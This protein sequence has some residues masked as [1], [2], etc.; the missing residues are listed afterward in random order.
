MIP[1]LLI[2][3]PLIA[4][5]ISFMLRDRA[6]G[7]WSLFA[8]LLTLVVSL[9]AVA[10]PQGSREL[11]VNLEWLSGLN[12]RFA[13]NLDGLALILCLLTTLAFPIIFIATGGE[14]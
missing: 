10:V 2:A 9:V 11:A 14:Q 8:S 1:V 4:G 12:S 13:L 5:L 3:V 6:S 7:R